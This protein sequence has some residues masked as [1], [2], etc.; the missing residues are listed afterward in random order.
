MAKIGGIGSRCDR[1]ARI[2]GEASYFADARRGLA[3]G[4]PANQIPQQFD[5]I[6]AQ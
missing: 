2:G 6:G 4:L 5:G 1:R 3:G